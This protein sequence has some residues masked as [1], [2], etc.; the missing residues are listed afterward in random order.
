MSERESSGTPARAAVVVLAAGASTRLG[1]PKQL[2]AYRGSTLLAHAAATALAARVG[3]V[4]VVLGA[5][6]TDLMRD[7]LTALDVEIVDNP[8]WKTG[9]STS[10][11]AGVAAAERL[12]PGVGALVIMTCDQPHVP[13]RILRELADAVTGTGKRLAACA[14]SGA[15]GIPAAFARPVFAE[16]LRMS[17]DQ[18]ARTLL[19]TRAEEVAQLPCPEAAVDV[20]SDADLSRLEP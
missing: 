14:Y 6:E 2:L 18:G 20:D 19:L 10:L 13:P 11:R 5:G 4:L 15:I 7:K 17:G 16:L 3:P 9:L 12:F 1:R 8:D